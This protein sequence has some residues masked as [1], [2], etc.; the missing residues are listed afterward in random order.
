M[1]LA[2][3]A[4][5]AA[6]L[7]LLAPATAQDPIPTPISSA[8]P[9]ANVRH[10]VRVLYNGYFLG[11]R[12]MKADV[13]STVADGVY[14]AQAVFRTAGLVRMFKEARITATVNGVYDGEGVQPI[15]F[16]HTN[17]ASS[18]NRRIQ[19]DWTEDDVIPTVTPPFGSMGEPP[20]TRE[21]R[22]GSRDVASMILSMT[23]DGGDAPCARTLPVFDGKQRYDIRLEP[24]AYEGIDLRGYEGMGWRC[25]LYYTPV[26]GFDPEDL[27]DPED[28]AR[29]M[30]IWLADLGEGR[31]PP[32]RL[33]GR[34]SG[35]GV[36][37]EAKSVSVETVAEPIR[38]ESD[39]APANR[40]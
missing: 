4:A 6:L 8:T 26:S 35:I 25:H 18:K 5:A 37:V 31:W 3:S 9:A 17:S 2:T 34:V 7:V 12:V 21:E 33:R 11:Q 1:R 13:T 22:L 16:E 28:Y 24:V 40:G 10:E 29:P 38:A 20:A 36:T 23:L 19:I 32:V 15:H 27:A 14:A 39:E 30:D